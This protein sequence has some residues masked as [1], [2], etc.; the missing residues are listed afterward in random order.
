MPYTASDLRKGLKVEMDG[1]PYV[2]TEFQFVKPGKGAAIYNCRLKSMIDGSTI[3]KAFRS[4]DILDKPDL[5][6]HTLRY[7]YSEGD[8]FIFM[9]ENFEQVAIPGS[10]LGDSK[11]FLYEDCEVEVLFHNGRPVEVTLPTFVEKVI[12]ETEPGSRG[13]TVQNVTKPAK[14]AGGYTLQVPLFVNQGDT[15]KIDTRT[16]EYADRVLK[17]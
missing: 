10:V 8:D 16:G 3:T 9:N 11:Y 1:V 2:I 6:E 15:I 14:I 13:N 17:K 4:N 5:E 7:S 12:V